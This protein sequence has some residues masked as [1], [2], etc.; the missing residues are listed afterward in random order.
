MRAIYHR[1][2]PQHGGDFE[3]HPVGT[4][5]EIERLR[6]ALERIVE[7]TRDSGS[8]PAWVAYKIA[9]EALRDE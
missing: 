6:P 5:A 1:S 4:G 3:T 2:L 9:V 7:E 8:G